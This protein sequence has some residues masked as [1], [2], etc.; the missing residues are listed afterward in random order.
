MTEAFLRAVRQAIAPVQHGGWV[1]GWRQNKT[2]PGGALLIIPLPVNS[3]ERDVLPL[4][5]EKRKMLWTQT[6][7]PIPMNKLPTELRPKAIEIANALLKQGAQEDK[8]VRLGMAT[9][10]HWSHL[11]PADFMPPGAAPMQVRH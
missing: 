3:R 1:N 7:Y 5:E 4:P 9:A 2:P 10:S 6:N 8:A 11:Y